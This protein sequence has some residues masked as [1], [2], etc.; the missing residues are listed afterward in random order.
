MNGLSIDLRNV[1]TNK[2]NFVGLTNSVYLQDG[3][4]NPPAG[5]KNGNALKS[6]W[7]DLELGVGSV[8]TSFNAIVKNVPKKVCLELIAKAVAG[9]SWQ[10]VESNGV[11]YDITS[12]PAGG[13]PTYLQ[14]ACSAATNSV[15]LTGLGK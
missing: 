8:T 2:P 3:K 13:L 10:K 1:Y 7:G 5:L 15:T 6:P 14:S 12:P 4:G 9:K 11:T